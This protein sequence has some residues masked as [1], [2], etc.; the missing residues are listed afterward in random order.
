MNEKIIQFLYLNLASCLPH[1]S[2][3]RKS[4]SPLLAKETATIGNN[5]IHDKNKLQYI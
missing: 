2:N 1:L 3:S 5:N 4:L